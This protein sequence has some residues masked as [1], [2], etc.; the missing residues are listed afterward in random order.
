MRWWRHWEKSSSTSARS[1]LP[2]NNQMPLLWHNGKQLHLHLHGKKKINFHGTHV[3]GTAQPCIKCEWELLIRGEGWL[4]LWEKKAQQPHS[5]R[6]QCVTEKP[7]QTQPDPDWKTATS[8]LV[9]E[10]D[11]EQRWVSA[12]LYVIH[13]SKG[14]ISDPFNHTYNATATAKADDGLDIKYTMM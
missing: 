12:A 5:F 4:L 9:A 10:L 1:Q 13:V 7:E 14:L 11:G 8:H 3:I 6:W 2:H